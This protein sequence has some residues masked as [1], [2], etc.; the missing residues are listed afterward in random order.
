M[1]K[2]MAFFFTFLLGRQLAATYPTTFWRELSPEKRDKI[3]QYVGED[4][5]N[6]SP[7]C[8]SVLLTVR[9]EGEQVRIYAKCKKIRV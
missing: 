9:L 4:F 8:R 6:E 5:L 2:I 1:N 3:L 7:W